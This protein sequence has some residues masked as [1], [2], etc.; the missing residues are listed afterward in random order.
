MQ[1]S[2]QTSAGWNWFWVI[3]LLI[4]T[5][6]IQLPLLAIGR[7]TVLANVGWSIL[8]LTGFGVTIGL[9]W[10]RYRLVH[11]RWTALTAADWRL[12]IGGY[13]IIIVS[14][15]LLGLVNQWWFHQ[16]STVNNQEIAQLLGRGP[17]V[18]VLLSTTAILASPILEEIIFRGLLIDGCLAGWSFWPPILASGI[19]FSLLH[20]SSN[21]VSW[22]I[23]AV[24]G[25]VFAY[26]YRR[27][28]KIQSNVMMH[29]FNNL[30]AIGAMLMTLR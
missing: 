17:V 2:K 18:L 30:L 22:L 28:D 23:Y 25:G 27:T 16:S 3:I 10:W 19:A 8:Y 26:V 9:A 12:M 29:A 4:L 20:Q 7:G 5:S 14:E 15:W 24:M 11:P 6:L 21:P 1:Q 13:A